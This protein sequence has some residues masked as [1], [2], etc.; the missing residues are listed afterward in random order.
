MKQREEIMNKFI[1]RKIVKLK[2]V[3]SSYFKHIDSK[4]QGITVKTNCTHK[5]S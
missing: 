2:I 1:F 4:V 3:Y 5:V